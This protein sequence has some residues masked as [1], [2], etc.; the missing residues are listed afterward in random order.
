MVLLEIHQMFKGHFMNELC[1]SFNF[2]TSFLK[3]ENLFQKTEAP[4]FIESTMIK[5]AT[6]PKK[7]PCQKPILRQIESGVQDGLITKNGVLPV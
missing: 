7:L 1:V 5:K 4:F 6:F 2:E 3:N